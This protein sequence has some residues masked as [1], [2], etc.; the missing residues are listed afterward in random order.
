MRVITKIERVPFVVQKDASIK[1][2]IMMATARASQ[3]KV[4]RLVCAYFAKGN[5]CWDEMKPY[6]DEKNMFEIEYNA[7]NKEDADREIRHIKEEA[8]KH[9][10]KSTLNRLK[11]K[12][13][14]YSK[15]TDEDPQFAKLCTNLSMLSIFIEVKGVVDS[16]DEPKTKRFIKNNKQKLVYEQNQH[17]I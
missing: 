5:G 13:K 11:R 6:I 2:R 10:G 17:N 8:F 9:I 1:E 14:G 15:V 3:N 16:L 12:V 7:S 4:W